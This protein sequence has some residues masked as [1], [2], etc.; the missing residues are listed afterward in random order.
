LINVRLALGGV[1]SGTVPAFDP[2]TQSVERMPYALA[3]AGGLLFY[4][5]WRL[6]GGVPFIVA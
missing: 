2:A 6:G 5:A 4:G 3:F 1:R